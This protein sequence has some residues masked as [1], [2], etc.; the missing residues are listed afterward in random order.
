MYNNNQS[1]KAHILKIQNEREKNDSNSTSL[2]NTLNANIQT[3]L[4]GDYKFVLELLQNTDDAPILGKET[5]VQIIQVNG[6]LIYIHNGKP[7]SSV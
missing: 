6:Y 7:F 2:A 4:S 3:A 1:Q 5:S